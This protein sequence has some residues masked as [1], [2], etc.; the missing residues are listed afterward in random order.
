MFFIRNDIFY[1]HGELPF[2]YIEFYFLL[3][4]FY[5]LRI[6]FRGEGSSSVL[7]FSDLKSF[8][9]TFLL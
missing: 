6:F 8:A 2:S 4:S 5:S 1:L 3:L 9:T 7:L